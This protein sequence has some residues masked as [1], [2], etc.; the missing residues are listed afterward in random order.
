MSDTTRQQSTNSAQ[1][2]VLG[3]AILAAV[4]LYNCF[5][6]IFNKLKLEIK[7]YSNLIIP[8]LAAPILATSW[9][10]ELILS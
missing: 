2:V 4:G 3:T 10:L 5:S 9:L 1:S 8:A 7:F 6:P